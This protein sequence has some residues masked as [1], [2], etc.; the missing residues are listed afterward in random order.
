[1]YTFS[2]NIADAEHIFEPLEG[3]SPPASW[4]F[5]NITLGDVD[6]P[7]TWDL[8]AD[9]SVYTSSQTSQVDSKKVTS[10]YMAAEMSAEETK[11]E[12]PAVMTVAGEEGKL[13]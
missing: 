4:R 6:V 13:P 3:V 10:H 11:Q 7:A 1:M 5:S 9:A 2:A 12:A 8:S